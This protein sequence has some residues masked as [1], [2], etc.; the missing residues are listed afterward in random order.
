VSTAL[1]RSDDGGEHWREMARTRGPMLGFAIADDGRTLWIGG[2]DDGLL[3]SDDGGARW[4]RIGGQQVLCLRQHEGVL[5][6]CANFVRDGYALGRSRDRGDSVQ[7]LLRFQDIAGPVACPAGSPESG[8]CGPRWPLVQRMFGFGDTGMDA[9]SDA[10]RDATG[11]AEMSPPRG[12]GCGVGT[13]GAAGRWLVVLAVVLAR[14][15]ALR[16]TRSPRSRAGTLGAR[17]SLGP[18]LPVIPWP[19]R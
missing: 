19:P 1:L 8:L 7:P 10:A 17:P 3:R 5:Y 14:R 6:V 15:S 18:S 4:Q 9:G 12:C 13:R 16:G 2:P 11:D